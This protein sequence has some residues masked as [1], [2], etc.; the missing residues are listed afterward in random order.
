MRIVRSLLKMRV[1]TM[2]KNVLQP[3]TSFCGLDRCQRERERFRRAAAAEGEDLAA[4]EQQFDRTA[5]ACPEFHLAGNGTLLSLAG[6]SSIENKGVG[7][8]D[9]L[10]QILASRIRVA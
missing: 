5:E 3:S 1:G 10:A 6:N 7:E 2:G 8:L 9:G 4:I